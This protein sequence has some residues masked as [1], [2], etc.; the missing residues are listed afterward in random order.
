[1][2][3]S[4]PAAAADRRHE[5][6]AV[7]GRQHLSSRAARPGALR[8]LVR[9]SAADPAGLLADRKHHPLLQPAVH[10]DVRARGVRH[11]PAGVRPDRR[12]P[13]GVRGRT[14]LWIS[15]VPHRLDPAPAGDEFAVDAVRAVGI[16]SFRDDEFL[17]GVGRRHGGARDAE[18]VVRLLPA[19]LRALRAAVRVAPHV[20][21]EE[22]RRPANVGWSGRRRGRHA[23]ADIAVPASVHASAATIRFRTT[24][25]RGGAV[26]RERVVIRHGVRE[27]V[28]VRHGA[29]LLSAR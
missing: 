19:L 14:G 2:G 27:P 25:R 15:P 17:S 9:T 24:L 8:A 6:D 22:A 26:L 16:E 21:G 3:R 29:A 12:P 28:V 11:L 5:L 7:L 20:G 18:L 10:L 4:A 1:M 23:G 13:R